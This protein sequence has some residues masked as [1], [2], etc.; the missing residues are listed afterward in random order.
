MDKNTAL[1]LGVAVVGLFAVMMLGQQ[2]QQGVAPFLGQP[3]AQN[4]AGGRVGPDGFPL[5][6]D[7]VLGVL[8]RLTQLG[9]SI[10]DTVQS[11]RGTGGTTAGAGARV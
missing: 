6:E 1:L 4:F 5:P 10:Y 8:E 7:R 11:R 2:G 3:G 9:G